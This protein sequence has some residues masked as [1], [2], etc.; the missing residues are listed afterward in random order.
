VHLKVA[1][2]ATLITLVTSP[3]L[4][5]PEGESTKILRNIGGGLLVIEMKALG[6]FETAA[7]YLIWK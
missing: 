6:S 4:L 5:D 7:D 2:V 1:A 3:G